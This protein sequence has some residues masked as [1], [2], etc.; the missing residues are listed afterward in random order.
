MTGRYVVRH[1]KKFPLSYVSPKKYVK[2][3]PN[4]V[5]YGECVI[6]IRPPFFPNLLKLTLNIKR[7]IK[8]KTVSTDLFFY[9]ILLFV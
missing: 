7:K 5:Y 9:V 4:L 1:L 2:V 3:F 6:K 8:T